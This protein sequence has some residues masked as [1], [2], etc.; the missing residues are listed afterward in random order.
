MLGGLGSFSDAEV[1]EDGIE[2]VFAEVLSEDFGEG[3]EGGAEAG[4]G[5]EV[6]VLA[7][8]LQEGDAAGDLA[9]GRL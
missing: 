1:G 7:T 2:G 6:L 5:G 3:F 8:G 9:S 4:G